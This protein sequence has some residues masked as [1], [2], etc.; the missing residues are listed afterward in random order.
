MI[1]GT[2]L[3]ASDNS[4]AMKVKCLKILGSSYCNHTNIGDSLVV[5][6]QSCKK[7]KKVVRRSVHKSILIR[8]KSKTLRKNGV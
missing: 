3:V 6:V 1:V 2:N 7:H 8:Q 5:S 4:G